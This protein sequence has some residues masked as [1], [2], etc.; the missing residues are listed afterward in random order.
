MF[1]GKS[2]KLIEDVRMYTMARVCVLSHILAGE[3]PWVYSRNGTRVACTKVDDLM[4]VSHTEYD[5]YFIDEAQ[6]FTN[7]VPFV[8]LCLKE[9]N[10][11]CVYGLNSDFRG[12]MM[13]QV[14]QLIPHADEIT[15]LHAR[16][17]C[18]H[19]AIYSERMSDNERLIDVDASYQPVCRRC[20]RT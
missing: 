10:S 12:K 6:F 15:L 16:C 9:G 4:L 17:R 5:V 14:Y 20:R 18:G 19:K 7:L 2:K 13:G 8:M 3:D 11:V 1:S